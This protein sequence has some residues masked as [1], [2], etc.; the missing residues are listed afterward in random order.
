M[1]S[2]EREPKTEAWGRSPQRG[3]RGQSPLRLPEAEKFL[4]SQCVTDQQNLTLLGL[5]YAVFYPEIHMR[6]FEP[7]Q[8][9]GSVAEG[10]R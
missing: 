2:A 10:K 7:A 3:S 5:I 6:G 8:G 9:P 1:A 4:A